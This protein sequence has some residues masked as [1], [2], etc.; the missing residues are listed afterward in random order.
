VLRKK[1]LLVNPVNRTRPGL[2]R[3]RF[4]R[5]PPLGL[6][7]IAALTPESW[8]V[9]LVDEN[10]ERF[11]YRDADL[12]GITSFTSSASRAYKIASLFR[13]RRV[14]VVM[15]GVH[16]S[17]CPEEA[18][19]YVDSVVAGEAENVWPEVVADAERGSLKRLYRGELS[20]MRDLPAPRHDLFDPRY[21]IECVETSRGCPMDCE[22]CS[23]TV[24]H[25]RRSRLRPVEEVLDELGSIPQRVFF[26]VDGNILGNT[27]EAREGALALFKGMVGRKLRKWWFCMASM[28]FGEDPELLRW[29]FRAGCRMVFIGVEAEKSEM[30]AEVNKRT[31]L[32]IGPKGFEERFRRINEAGI[33]VLGSF[34]FGL[35]GD[36]ARN[37]RDRA[38]YMLE[39]RVDAVQVTYLTPLPGTRLFEKIKF[40]DRLLRDEFPDDWS[41]YDFAEVVYRPASMDPHLLVEAMQ[42][43]AGRVY[44]WPS[45]I[46]KGLRTFRKTGSPVAAAIAFQSNRVYRKIALAA[47]ERAQLPTKTRQTL[48]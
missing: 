46:R 33:A 41:R 32:R 20:S 24:F 29:A 27:R 43:C 34:L 47:L 16:A 40:Q 23:V 11:R 1:L 45:M 15:G 9:E 17:T 7:M 18:L 28:G 13:D 3:D 36:R 12:V 30:L 37:L 21:L 2:S 42:E 48:V 14:P 44:S 22:F 26:F 31:N 39:S 5:F 25:G 8:D 38:T 35:D 6:G 19:R 10:W 4:S